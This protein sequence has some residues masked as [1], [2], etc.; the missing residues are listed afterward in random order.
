MITETFKIE[1]MSC[2]HCIRAVAQ[3]LNTLPVQAKK[4]DL[5][6]AL[7]EYDPERV[8][9]VMI[10]LAIREAGYGVTPLSNN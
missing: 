3:E 9:R 2:E 7:V 5:G 8:S 1:G 4:I 10:E 6:S